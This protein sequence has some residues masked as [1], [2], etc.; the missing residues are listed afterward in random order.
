MRIVAII[1]ILAALLTVTAT[2]AAACPSGYHRCGGAC[3]PG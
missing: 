1:G 3:C 2:P